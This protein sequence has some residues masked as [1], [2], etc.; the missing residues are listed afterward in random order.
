MKI[1]NIYYEQG[2]GSLDS[3]SSL[4]QSLAPILID[5]CENDK[6]PAA[7]KPSYDHLFTFP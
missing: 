1:V 5:S 6:V 3:Q 4:C 7:T 2:L